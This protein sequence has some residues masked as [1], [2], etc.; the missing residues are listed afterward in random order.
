M[1]SNPKLIFCDGMKK[2]HGLGYSYAGSGG[3]N[4]D[5]Y[6]IDKMTDNEFSNTETLADPKNLCKSMHKS[7]M[8]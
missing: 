5:Y 2:T 3:H 6:T 4:N 8:I 1:G 7:L